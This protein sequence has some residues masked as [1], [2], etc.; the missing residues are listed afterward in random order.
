MKTPRQVLA[1]DD[2]ER[3]RTFQPS[4]RDGLLIV[5]LKLGFHYRIWQWGSRAFA[6]QAL[7]IAGRLDRPTADKT[8]IAVARWAADAYSVLSTSLLAASYAAL[9]AACRRG[10]PEPGAAVA[11]LLFYP[12]ARTGEILSVTVLHNASGPY[13]SQAPL[14][15]VSRIFWCYLEVVVAFASFFCVAGRWSGDDFAAGR[16]DLLASWLDPLYFSLTTISTAGFGD[17]APT[18]AP[19]KL[20]VMAELLIGIVLVVLAV[21]RALAASTQAPD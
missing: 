7:R 17:Y 3:A 4:H 16:G 14:R 6:R 2:A 12:V 20:L 15:A 19:G 9:Y 11:L 8:A 21:Q 10:G 5:L 1:E 13:R 18:R